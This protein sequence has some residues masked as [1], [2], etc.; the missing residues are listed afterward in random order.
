MEFLAKVYAVV[1]P[2]G[3]VIDRLLLSDGTYETYDINQR[4]PECSLI[5][6]EENKLPI[7]HG[8]PK[9]E[10]TQVPAPKP[11]LEEVVKS[12]DPVRKGVLLDWLQ[13][14]DQA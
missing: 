3:V 13:S 4:Y 11:T 14:S 12:L 2:D 8:R 10:V 1:T 7:G 6:D 9:S 5:L